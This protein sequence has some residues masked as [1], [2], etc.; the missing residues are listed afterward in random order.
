MFVNGE[1]LGIGYLS[2]WNV[3]IMWMQ[4]GNLL[5]AHIML[6]ASRKCQWQL[7]LA[8]SMLFDVLDSIITL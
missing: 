4:N 5:S 8:L 3:F 6:C 7:H 1:H 2:M